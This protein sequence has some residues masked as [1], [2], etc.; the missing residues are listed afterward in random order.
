MDCFDGVDENPQPVYHTWK[1]FMSFKPGIPE[2]L[3]KSK[4]MISKH[5]NKNLEVKI[6]NCF[7]NKEALDLEV[8]LKALEEDYQFLSNKTN[9][10]RKLPITML[11]KTYCA[12]VQDWY[13]KLRELATNM[14]EVIDLVADKVHKRKLKSAAWV[15][16][17]VNQYQYQVLDGRY[18][19]EVNLM[20]S[21]C[22][23]WFK[24]DKYQG[25]YA[26]S[27]H[28]LEICKNGNFRAIF[29]M[30]FLLEWTTHNPVVQKYKPYIS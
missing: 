23:F 13:F 4:P 9:P 3:Y 24:K 5:Y 10:D 21:S 14:N 27:I 25:T 2:P 30:L 16:H 29:I 11:T 17:D 12:M 20:T 6:G 26:E 22:E 8:R 19:R 7:N 18:N 15:V 28:F 1:K